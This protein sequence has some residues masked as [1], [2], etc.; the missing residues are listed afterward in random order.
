MPA[1][2]HR[3][4]SSNILA[5]HGI[6]KPDKNNQSYSFSKLTLFSSQKAMKCKH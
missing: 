3:C 5:L 6:E 2:V 1:L 4:F